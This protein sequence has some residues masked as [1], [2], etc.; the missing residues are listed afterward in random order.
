MGGARI[1]KLA[2]DLKAQAA[3][4][5]VFSPMPYHA[6]FGHAD[7]PAWISRQVGWLGKYLGVSGVPG[8]RLRIWPIVQISDWGEP[9][10]VEQ[11]DEVL[12]RGASAPATGV[13]VFAWGGLRAQPRKI[14]A[15]GRS[16]R[17]LAAP[18]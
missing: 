8:E 18:D 16:F 1:A 3:Y 13:M 6:R 7:D 14:E 17:A 11:V 2:I 9:V 4:I 10:P 15:I 5:D 12:R